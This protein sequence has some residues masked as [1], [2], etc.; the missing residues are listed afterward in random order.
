MIRETIFSLKAARK[1]FISYVFLKSVIASTLWA[2]MHAMSTRVGYN[3]F[4]WLKKYPAYL[5]W[6]VLRLYDG[7]LTCPSLPL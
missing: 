5:P 3:I 2:D 7:A 6:L 4:F 1:F